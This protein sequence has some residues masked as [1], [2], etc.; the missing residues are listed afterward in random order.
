MFVKINNNFRGLGQNELSVNEGDI[1]EVLSQRVHENDGWW[2]GVRYRVVNSLRFAFEHT[3]S[4][5]LFALPLLVG[6]VSKSW[7][8]PLRH[9]LDSSTQPARVYHAVRNYQLI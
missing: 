1:I 2:T 4:I 8:V 7:T 6:Q 5:L 3:F 9:C